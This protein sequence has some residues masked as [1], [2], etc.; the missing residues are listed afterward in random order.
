MS[1]RI[2]TKVMH[3]NTLGDIFCVTSFG[4]SHGPAVGCVIDGVPAGIA[5]DMQA[6][7]QEVNARKTG[8]AAYASARQEED[9]VEILSGV[10]EGKTLGSPICIVIKNQDAKPKDY[11]ALKDV[12][13]PN[14]GDYTNH[15]KYGFRDHRGGGRTSIRVTAPLVAAGDIARQVLQHFSKAKV[16]SAVQSIGTL[17]DLSSGLASCDQQGIY[18]N[19]Y[20]TTN[21]GNDAKLDEL[22]E[23]YAANGDT[24]GGSISSAILN[25][26]AGIG[27]PIFSKLNSKLGQAMLSIN[28]V[29]AIEFGDGIAAS[30]QNGSTHAD[31]FGIADEQVVT[32]SNHS[33]GI[34][35]GISNGMPVLFTTYFK[36]ISS[37]KQPQSTVDSANTATTINIEGRHDVCAVPRAVPIVNAYIH[38]VLLNEVLKQQLAKI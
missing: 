35:G 24:L 29:K 6:I 32:T 15:A 17:S 3:N 13:R 8:Q 10:F 27:S 18:N 9:T 22:I 28:T 36:P 14:H 37:I 2:A 7:Q 21:D 20:R 1:T 38:I 30:V 23:A 5:L 26:E 19:R 25:L 33:G 11:D 12:F 4:E 16:L 34:Q 31:E